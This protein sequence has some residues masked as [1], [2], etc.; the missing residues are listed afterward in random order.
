MF[1]IIN[2]N[3]NLCITLSFC[4]DFV[5]GDEPIVQEG[6]K[7]VTIVSPN[8]AIFTATVKPGEPRA[9]VQ[10]FKA[11]RKISQDKKYTMTFEDDLV[12]LEVKDTKPEDADQFSFEAVNKVG[13]VT[14]KASLTVHGE[15]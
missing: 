2:I 6:L 4:Y 14:S 9:D 15:Y 5:V 8:T 7:D 10:W 11:G 13:K 1:V 3:R 12:T